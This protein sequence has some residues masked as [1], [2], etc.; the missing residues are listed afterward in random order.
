M[1]PQESIAH[2]RISGKLGEGGMGAV[3]RATDT[4]LN[5][6]VAIKVIPET[7]AADPDR[8]ARFAREAQV[9]ASLNHPNI[10]AIYGVE[11][12]ALVMELVEGATLAERIAPG[13]VPIEEAL[14]IARQIAEALEYAHEKGIVHRD[15]KPANV[16]VTPEGR[17]KVLDFGL[18]KALSSDNS[19]ADPASSPTLTMRATMAGMIMGTASYMAPEQ[20]KGKPVDRRADIWSYGVLLAELLTGAQ[21]YT[22]ETVS[23]T[24]AAVLLKDPDLTRLPAATPPAIRRLLRRCLERD[25]SR[26][27]QAIGEARIAIDEALAGGAVL[28]EVPG[29]S[30][31]PATRQSRLPWALAGV[32]VAVA[33][34]LGGLLWRATRAPEKQMLRFSADM[35]SDAEAGPRISAAIT[36]DGTRIAY[37][38]RQSSG[39]N[40]LATRLMDQSKPTVLSGTEGAADP[41]FSPDGQW[42]VFFADGHLKK[43]SIQGGAPSTLCEVASVRGTDWG[44]DGNLVFGSASGSGLW[45]VPA[46]GGKQ[47]AL[48]KPEDHGELSH[49]WPQILP[50]GEFILFTGHNSGANFDD[51]NVE[52]LALKTGQIKMLVHGGYFGRYLPSG[53]LVYLHQGTLFAMAYDLARNEPRGTPVPVLE[54]VAGNTASAG[55]QLDFS[56]TGTIVYLAGKSGGFLSTVMSMDAAGKT[57]ALMPQQRTLSPR[58]SPDGKRLTYVSNGEIVVFD[59]AR[60]T[61]TRVSAAQN[62]VASF[63]VWTPDGKHIA[64]ASTGIWWVR[65]DGSAPQVRLYQ[66]RGSPTPGSFSPDG[67]HLA[68]HQ[69]GDATN[70]DLWIL[71]VDTADPDNP[72]AGTPELFLATK[73]SDV[74]PAFSPDGR[75][76]AY[77]SGGAAGFHIFVRPYPEGAQGGGQ[78]QIS[79]LPGRLPEWSRTARELF[80][81]AASGQLMVVPYRING[82]TFEPEKARPWTAR[83]ILEFGNFPSYDLAPDGKHVA[84]FPTPEAGAEKTNLHL[85]FLLN[86]FDELKRRVP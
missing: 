12:H 14:P 22:G 40:W 80:Y 17:V 65:A 56:R 84:V 13:A 10:A 53:H 82:R 78:V 67:H 52:V 23:E 60:G 46:A 33:M 39:P 43:T 69:G 64:F 26:R 41:F 62:G 19:A 31:A 6:D 27:L 70:R 71:P 24:L 37:S 59:L 35:G 50:G 68:Y 9:L 74:E 21:L 2:Y 25:P 76:L 18:A 63:P 48:T 36:R 72:K 54:D 55:G 4:K 85:T 49:R 45:R 28:E 7:F 30:L 77:A 8:M 1:S 66:N 5:R 57:E 11:E 51:A 38:I 75:W 81:V 42:I 15:L 20:A 29:A 86:F 16:K 47:V 32:C 61:A 58:F 73:D 83:K 44:E 3:Y 79:T 34:A